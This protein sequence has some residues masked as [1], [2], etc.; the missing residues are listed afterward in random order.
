MLRRRLPL[1]ALLLLS[2]LA[3]AKDK[4]KTPLPEDVLRA[5][6]VWVIVDPT[7]GVDINAPN[8]NRIARTD[9]EK[10]LVDWGR[11]EPVT[12]ADMAD[13]IITVRKGNGKVANGTIGGTPVNAPPPVIAQSTDNNIHVAGGTRGAQ[14]PDRT[15]DASSSSEAP[16]PDAGPSTNTGYPAKPSPQA[17]LGLSQDMFVVYR[18]HRTN[19]L[20]APPVWRYSAKDAL[21]SPD[22]PVVEVFRTLVAQSEKQLAKTP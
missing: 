11:L 7:A 14:I 12:N 9:V 2:P 19:A 15:P 13:L 5:H 1:I 6:T 16:F 21:E 4:K 10:A 17:E 18:S 8:A 20:D 22:V 3:P